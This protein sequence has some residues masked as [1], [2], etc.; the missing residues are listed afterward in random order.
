MAGVN[1][2][3]I[4]GDSRASVPALSRRRLG[5]FLDRGMDPGGGRRRSDRGRRCSRGGRG[6]RSLAR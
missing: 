3:P 2:D 5:P 1:G 6:V 4:A